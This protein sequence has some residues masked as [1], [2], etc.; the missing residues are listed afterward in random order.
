MIV[1]TTKGQKIIMKGSKEVYRFIW[2]LIIAMQPFD[3]DKEHLFVI[4]INRAFHVKYL[5]HVAMGTMHETIA[6][7]REIFRN[8]IHLGASA[9]ILAHNHPSGSI[10]PSKEDIA[11]TKRLK[12]AGDLLNIKVVDHLIVAEEGYFSI[13][14]EGIV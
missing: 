11:M 8:A 1:E 12:E 10:I 4:G 2:E 13:T 14:D 7:P 3:R 5:D 6:G 9:I